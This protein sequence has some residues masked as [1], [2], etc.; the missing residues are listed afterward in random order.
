MMKN[1]EILLPYQANAALFR[2]PLCHAA[3][4]IEGASFRCANGHCYDVSAK[5]YLNFCPRGGTAHYSP[6]LFQS[7]RRVMESG[8]FDPVADAILAA[9]ADALGGRPP[10]LLDAGCGEGTLS[11]AVLRG[12]PRGSR[13]IGLDIERAAVQLACRE[14]RASCW[15]VGDVDNLP[16]MDGCVDLLTNILTPASYGGF[17][18]VLKPNG[19]LVKAVPGPDHLAEIRRAIAGQLSHDSYSNEEVLALFAKNMQSRQIVELRYTRPV[20]PSLSEALFRMT[21][22][23]HQK[24]A[25]GADTPALREATVH[26]LLLCG[27]PPPA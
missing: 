15:L 26:L 23:T 13:L 6:A 4:G 12:L 21:P 14:D 7:R 25:G 16:I 5:G 24:E 20:E 3:G 9:A 10:T 18:R 8:L 2:C 19:L 11:R 22:M 17:R 27:R 1:P